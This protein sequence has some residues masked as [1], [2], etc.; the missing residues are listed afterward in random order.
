MVTFPI[1]TI[2]TTLTQSITTLCEGHL[3]VNVQVPRS[4]HSIQQGRNEGIPGTWSQRVS[5]RQHKSAGASQSKSGTLHWQRQLSINVDVQ[6]PTAVAY[7]I[8]CRNRQG[9]YGL[10]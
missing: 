10:R 1:A 9:H 3:D 2:E 8:L 4:P 6:Q 5:Y 7:L